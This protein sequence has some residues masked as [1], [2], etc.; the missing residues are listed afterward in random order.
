MWRIYPRATLAARRGRAERR[1]QAGVHSRYA[2]GRIGNPARVL[3]RQQTRPPEP[4][5]SLVGRNHEIQ[6]ITGLLGR[7]GTRHLTLSGPGGIGKTRLALH[8]AQTV[9][10]D[11]P[12]GVHFIDLAA[13]TDHALVPHAIAAGVG[14][15]AAEPIEDELAA[16]F[17][18]RAALL[19]LDNFEHLIPAGPLVPRLAAA[20]PDLVILV[21]SRERLG[22]TGEQVI[23]I[24]PL[25]LPR[26]GEPPTV[27][28]IIGSP[29][30]QLFVERAAAA[31]PGFA[32]S[33]E[34][35]ADVAAIC[36]GLDGMPLAI[37][38]AAARVSHLAPAQLAAHVGG[39]LPLLSDGASDLPPRL[40]TMSD[41]VRWSYDLLAPEEQAFFRR[42]A[43]FAGGCTVEAATAAGW[44]PF[45]IASTA[46]AEPTAG[47][48]SE[49]ETIL[50]LASLTD[51]SL[52]RLVAPGGGEARYVMLEPVREFGLAELAAR[53]EERATRLAQGHYLL[54]YADRVRLESRGTDP[55]AW[56]QHL[57]AEQDNIRAVLRWLL[58]QNPAEGTLALEICNQVANFW[59]WRSQWSEAKSWL[60]RALA[61]A[62]DTVSEPVAEACLNLGHVEVGSAG[63]SFRWYERGLAVARALGH[64]RGIAVLLSC[65]GMTAEQMGNYAAARDY[66]TECLA[67]SEALA[68]DFGVAQASFHLGVVAGRMGEIEPGKAHLD[69]ARGLW[70]QLGDVA[71]IAFTIVELGRLYRLQGRLDE[72]ADLLDWSLARLEQTGISHAQGP[73]HY[74]RGEVALARGD[75]RAAQAEFREAIRLLRGA[76]IIHTQFAAAVDGLARIVLAERPDAA[77][78][79]FAAIAAWQHRT[80]FRAA[81]GEEQVRDQA[82]ADGKRLLGADRYAVMWERG[83]RGTLTAASD[84]V[85]TIEVAVAAPAAAPVPAR[86]TGP[87]VERLTRQEQRVLCLVVDGL[88][89]QQVADALSITVRTAANHVTN[90]LGKFSVDNRTQAA[91]VAFRNNMCPPAG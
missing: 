63:D 47:A 54:A 30:V 41:A 80:G 88:S 36:R 33:E 65:L 3:V 69:H 10:A 2:H 31:R 28:R 90:I 19:I 67:R 87:G 8:L 4:L 27:S 50:R 12:D 5:T 11:F 70:E 39:M 42:L 58:D 44:S 29:A 76:G 6:H 40:R 16:Y 61:Q 46:G 78:Q 38:L 15:T 17:A 14:L 85:A 66:L 52:L 64:E 45:Q 37:E 84:L 35:A 59:L 68:D 57:E 56:L 49:I 74:E 71:S 18:P 89:N 24:A 1:R 9:T 60:S 7:P 82:M 22:T 20:C 75:V 53:R 91:A 32:L 79:A 55:A 62:G 13:L 23:A 43:V 73:A 83:R 21:T 77:V 26:P 86:R 48:A 72:A 81:P 25:A 34:N 51:K